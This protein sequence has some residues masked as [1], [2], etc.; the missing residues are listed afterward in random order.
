M[1]NVW[2]N[3]VLLLVVFLLPWQTRFIFSELTISGAVSEYGILSVYAVECLLLVLMLMRGVP[4]TSLKTSK[5]VQA[6]YLVLA[7]GFFSLT[8][9]QFYNVSLIHMLHLIMVGALFVAITDQRTSIKQVVWVFL[10]GLIIPAFLGWYQVLT[11]AS[12]ASTLL[13][14]SGLDAQVLGTAVVENSSGR[15]LRAYGSF[16]HPNIF[17]GVLSVATLLLLWLSSQSMRFWSRIGAMVFAVLFSSTLL[18]TFSRSAW[19]ALGVASGLWV[20]MHLWKKRPIEA[21]SKIVLG[22]GLASFVVTMLVFSSHVLSRFDQSLPTESRSTHERIAQYESFDDVFFSQPVLGV[23][24]GAYTFMLGRIFPGKEVWAYQPIH[25]V[26]ALILAEAGVLG[27]LALFYWIVRIDQVSA[28]LQSNR[29]A[30][31]AVSFGALL[32][33]LGLFDHYL[34][35]LWSGLS[36]AVFVFSVLI[37]TGSLKEIE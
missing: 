36:L 28:S 32:L 12:A 29:H 4:Q 5:A 26:Y 15:L 27:L 35:S 7:A 6:M 21:F 13:G 34:W 25:N 16:P 3:N 10:F 2:S 37:K 11:G 18:I 30:I 17:G 8:F 33:F 24:S 9:S 20:G 23:G 19:I 31:F 22:L 1:K 14:L